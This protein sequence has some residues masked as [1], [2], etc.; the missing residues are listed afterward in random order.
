VRS[1]PVD[2]WATP[3]PAKLPAFRTS[4]DIGLAKSCTGLSARRKLAEPLVCDDQILF[5]LP[6]VRPIACDGRRNEV[7]EN[8]E[9]GLC[10]L[11]VALIAGLIK[12]AQNLQEQTPVERPECSDS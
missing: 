5:A 1:R 12:S 6:M 8:V 10:H 4:P 2:P 11:E 3:Q 7:P 9:E